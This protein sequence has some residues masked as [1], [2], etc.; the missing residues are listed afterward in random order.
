M[1]FSSVK[2][3]PQSKSNTR[4]RHFLLKK[5]T[6][7]I[8][9]ALLFLVGFL[10]TAP[11][12]NA[13]DLDKK[14][15]VCQATGNGSHHLISVNKK[16]LINGN[17]SISGINANDVVPPFDYNFGGSQYGHF[18]G[19]NWPSNEIGRLFMAGCAGKSN[20]LTPVLTKPTV[21]ATCINVQGEAPAVPTQTDSRITVGEPVFENGVWT[22][23][24]N[25]PSDVT[26][27]T[28]I[29]FESFVWASPFT[30]VQTVTVL[31][32]GPGDEF[33]DIKTNSCRTPDTGAGGISNFA[34]MV[35]GGALGLGM[36]F[37]GLTNFIGRRRN[38]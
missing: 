35:G 30:G 20:E 11:K 14:A 32:A 16:S 24:F 25:K 12:A 21:Q 10:Y 26:H 15:P 17:G 37:L 1:P 34:L 2:L 6:A 38:V 7:A 5:S 4:E 31:P 3:F 36:T 23:Q 8:I 27:N 29:T 33:W 19:H 9:L 18:A 13:S 28:P 22:L